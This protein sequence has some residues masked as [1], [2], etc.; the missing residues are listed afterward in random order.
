MTKLLKVSQPGLLFYIASILFLAAIT[1]I[2]PSCTKD[3]GKIGTIIQP[4]DSW[5][6]VR[7]T[8]TTSIAAYS[9]IDDS[10][11]TDELTR[12]AIGYVNDP[13]FGATKAS[14]YT[15][16]VLST[17][18]HNFGEEPHLDSLVLQLVYSGAYADTNTT[19]TLH[20][21]QISNIPDNKIFK[22]SAY[23]NRR[24]F[25]VG[26][27]DFSNF[28]FQP[29]PN[30]SV[31]IDSVAYPPLIRINLSDL[32]TELG[33]RLLSADSATNMVDNEAF[34]EFFRGLYL[35][36]SAVSSTGAFA[37]F[38]LISGGSKLSIYYSNQND[39]SLRYDFIISSSAAR[40]NKYEHDFTNASVDLRQQ[41]VNGDSTLGEQNFYIQGYAGVKT[42][43]K[44][45]YPKS[46]RNL[47]NV[48]VNEAKLTLPG[49][50]FAQ[51]YEAP[52]QLVLV[53]R[54]QDGSYELLPDY[55]DGVS[56][57]GGTY[58]AESN[59]YVFRI[60]KYI[61]SVISDSTTVNYGLYLLVNAGSINPES[62]IFNG[63]KPNVDTADRMKL[64]ILYTDLD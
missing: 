50:N 33:E 47:V 11:R 7:F 36:P 32:S 18:G 64:E 16:F 57:F 24:T 6:K 29:R 63:F 62:F 4:G 13:V 49:G 53:Q 2:L 34:L 21:Y 40:F 52:A 43:I 9:V 59:R 3:P 35:T 10:V 22:D 44:L 26:E 45:P 41:I 15:Q 46:W 28:S 14:F 61:Q 42:V 60:T 55:N 31:Y 30:D 12:N 23:Y 54:L 27:T 20:T 48:A 25:I 5:L 38:N 56:Y 17:N 19:L 51:F 58:E 1:L 37:Y 8:D 39:D